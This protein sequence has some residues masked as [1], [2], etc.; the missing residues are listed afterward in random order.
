MPKK[1]VSKELTDDD[2]PNISIRRE[3]FAQEFVANGGDASAAYR[4]SF[5]WEHMLTESVWS[6]AYRVRH[7]AHVAARIKDIQAEHETSAKASIEWRLS[8]LMDAAIVAKD[9]KATY[10]LVQAINEINKMLG[11]H[12][13][14][15]LGDVQVSI[16][17]EA[18]IPP[19][20]RDTGK[21]DG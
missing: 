11:G 2:V 10:G 16:N 21:T 3:R 1:K 4:S 8:M 9:K 20:S 15:D 7:S 14:A 13:T 6:S 12:K 17:T 5:A 19:N 18:T